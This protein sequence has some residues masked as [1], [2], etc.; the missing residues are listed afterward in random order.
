M[1]NIALLV[2]MIAV[3]SFDAIAQRI[4]TKI[5]TNS[6]FIRTLGQCEVGDKTVDCLIPINELK[7]L[8]KG[9]VITYRLDRTLNPIPYKSTSGKMKRATRGFIGGILIKSVPNRHSEYWN[10]ERIEEINSKRIYIH[11]S[12]INRREFVIEKYGEEVP[13]EPARYDYEYSWKKFNPAGNWAYY[14]DRAFQGATIDIV[15]EAPKD[16]GDFCPNYEKLEARED[17][18]A[19]WTEM[20]A[21]L[22]K[23]ESAFFPLTQN[24]EGLFDPRNQGVLSRGLLQISYGSTRRPAYTDQGCKPTGQDDMYDPKMNLTCGVAI[25]SYLS[26]KAECLSCKRNGRWRGAAA[27][28]STLRDPYEVPC[29]VCADGKVTIGK[30]GKVI[31]AMKEFAPC[32]EGYASPFVESAGGGGGQE[33]VPGD[34][35]DPTVPEEQPTQPDEPAQPQ[36]PTQPEQTDDSAMEGQMVE[37]PAEPEERALPE[38]PA[39]VDDS[40]ME[41]HMVEPETTEPETQPAPEVVEPENQP[42]P[43]VVEPEAQPAPEATQP[44]LTQPAA[45]TPPLPVRNPQRGNATDTTTSSDDNEDE[46]AITGFFRGVGDWFRDNF[47]GSGS[48]QTTDPDDR[49]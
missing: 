37:T 5:R 8:P 11:S 32:K 43:E 7:A 33:E 6:T 47:S 13:G 21:Q 3:V 41:G 34:V 29:S 18:I 31:K 28:W 36:E 20:F 19:V 27:Y 17:K 40:A 4:E 22:A 23:Y 15:T 38:Q 44:E 35:D 25:V 14:V 39:P 16:F 1:K 49:R 12:S 2:A 48:S 9:S 42:A 26:G 30:K 24:D 45:S 46:D 10:D